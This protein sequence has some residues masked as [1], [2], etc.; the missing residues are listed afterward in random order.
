MTVHI[1]VADYSAPSDRQLDLAVETLTR[2]KATG[3]GAAVHCAAGKGRTG[4]VLAAYWV[5]QGLTAAEAVRKV[6]AARPGSI[7]TS[8]QE[9]AVAEFEQRRRGAPAA[10]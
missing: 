8:E 10:E 7:E 3:L 2:A 4:T 6:R 1:P 9:R 5:A